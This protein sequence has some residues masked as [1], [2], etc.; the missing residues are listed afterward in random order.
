MQSLPTWVSLERLLNVLS[1][2]YSL[3]LLFSR[4]LWLKIGQRCPPRSEWLVGKGFKDTAFIIYS[5]D[6]ATIFC[7]RSY[8]ISAY[9]ADSDLA[10]FLDKIMLSG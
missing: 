8:Y 10:H 9:W 3:L 2:L 6:V 1:K 4:Y 5:A 7:W